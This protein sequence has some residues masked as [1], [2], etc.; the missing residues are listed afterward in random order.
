[1]PNKQ[2]KKC[3]FG[4]IN[5][6]KRTHQS[7]REYPIFRRGNIHFI[8]VISFPH[9]D[10]PHLKPVACECESDS[11]KSQRESNLLDLKEFKKRYSDCEIF[12]VTD[13]DEV[14]LKRLIKQPKLKKW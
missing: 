9:D 5:K 8:D 10:K 2:H 14:D 11:P 12:Q 3:V 6:L 7:I 1:M 4:V 13:A